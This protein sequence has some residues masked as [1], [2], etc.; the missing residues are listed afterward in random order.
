MIPAV[1]QPCG[2]RSMAA[3]QNEGMN[4]MHPKSLIY[5]DLFRDLPPAT[6]EAFHAIEVRK[7]YPAGAR[8][9]LR[10]Q[11]A[12]GVFI[13]HAGSVTLSESTADERPPSSR[14]AL[15]GEIL[16]VAATVSGDRHQL[17]AQTVEPSEIGFIDR[18]DLMYF[19]RTHGAAAFRL[20]Q[21]LSHTLD[22][23]LEY[24]RLLPP[25]TEA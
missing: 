14:L 3:R 8:L 20:V 6:L 10:G 2:D 1:R 19:L 9:F 13:L 12:S 21:L 17:D 11:V 15:P 18:E 23:A 24:A 25:V 7:P 16:G 22:A 5:E 4:L